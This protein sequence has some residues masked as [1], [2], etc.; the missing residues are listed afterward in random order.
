M[1][2]M[3]DAVALPAQV[4]EL[5]EIYIGEWKWGRKHGIGT[6]IWQDE[7]IYEGEWI[8]GRITGKG[9]LVHSSGDYY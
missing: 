7:S 6:Q 5:G 2:M 1:H 3:D 9:R 8:Q 4:G